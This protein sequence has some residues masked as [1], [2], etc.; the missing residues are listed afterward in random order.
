MRTSVHAGQRANGQTGKRQYANTEAVGQ[1]PHHLTTWWPGAFNR[2][3][4]DSLKVRP[5]IQDI[6]APVS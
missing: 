3:G 1:Q 4:A 2:H 5:V 6:S